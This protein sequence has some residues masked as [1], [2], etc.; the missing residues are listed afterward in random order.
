[1]IKYETQSA[2]AVPQGLI[3]ELENPDVMQS[4]VELLR[5]LPDFQKKMQSVED[6][7]LFGKAVLQDNQMIEKYEETASTFNINAETVMSLITLLE[8]LPK[9]VK[10]VEQLENITDF[11]SSIIGDKKSTDY[12][13]SNLKEY[14]DPIVKEGDQ[15]LNLLIEVKERANCS[16]QNVKFISMVKWLKDPTVQRGLCYVQATLDLLS[17]KKAR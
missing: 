15:A 14:A 9:I 16:P 7:L 12:L 4:L 5:M 3:S 10:M 2:N 6:V 1:M 11:V 17:E 8:K 13:F